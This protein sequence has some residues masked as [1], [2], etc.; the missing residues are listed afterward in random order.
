MNT[1]KRIGAFVFSLICVHLCSSA[2]LFLPG[3]SKPNAANITLRKENQE[4]QS[5]IEQLELARKTDTNAL[6][7]AEE[8][9]GT[10]QTLPHDRLAKLFA[11]NDLKIG[12]LT[13]GARLKADSKSD[14]ALKVYVVPTDETG[15]DVKAAGSF[16][17][18]AF[19][20]NAPNSPLVARWEFSTDEARK[21]WYGHALLYEY[22]L[23]LPLKTIPR[24]EMLTLKV[25]FIDELTQRRLEAQRVVKLTLAPTSATHPAVNVDP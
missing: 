12:R 10:L 22:V 8:S 17:V 18:E 2:V 15:D 3:C 9:K 5:R 4:L 13:G 1:D 23:P 11:A 6:R 20:L 25:T 21:H 16:I 24:H 19:D 7:A 14:D